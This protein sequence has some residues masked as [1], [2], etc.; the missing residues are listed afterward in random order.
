MARGDQ[1]YVMRDV[2][3]VPYWHHGIDCGNGTIIHY[4]KV[5]TPTVAC[6]SAEAFARGNPV[7]MFS[8]PVSFIPDVVISRA[9]SRLGEQRYNMFFNNTLPNCRINS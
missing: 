9:E 1:V 2:M 4:R 3:G 5:G 6:T 8:Q 7:Y